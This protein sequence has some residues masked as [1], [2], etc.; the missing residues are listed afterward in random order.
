VCAV[1]GASTRCGR[2]QPTAI[3]CRMQCK[4]RNMHHATCTMHNF[5]IHLVPH[6]M[7]HTPLVESC[8]G[9]LGRPICTARHPSTPRV[10]PQWCSARIIRRP[11]RSSAHERMPRH[12]SWPTALAIALASAG[13]AKPAYLMRADGLSP[14][15]VRADIRA[16]SAKALWSRAVPSAA[17]APPMPRTVS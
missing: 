7:H 12:R 1:S 11:P 13:E 15:L 14:R 3:S 6:T 17:A 4:P 8:Y 9:R 5:S 10:P 16:D 2:L